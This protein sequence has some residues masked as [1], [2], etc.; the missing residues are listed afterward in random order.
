MWSWVDGERV[1]KTSAVDIVNQGRRKNRVR[2]AR[3]A[4]DQHTESRK[5]ARLQRTRAQLGERLREIR[6]ARRLTLQE[7]A[8]QTGLAP[9]TLSKIEQARQIPLG[10]FMTRDVKTIHEEV[11][12]LKARIFLRQHGYGCLPV[13]Q[14][15]QL[16]GGDVRFWENSWKVLE[17]RASYRVVR[18]NA[19]PFSMFRRYSCRNS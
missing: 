9:S 7:A 18:T 3:V 10:T 5:P 8:L 12:L 1:W 13:V 2:V 4:F 15:G 11:S 6:K 16:T 19:P 14:D 17:A